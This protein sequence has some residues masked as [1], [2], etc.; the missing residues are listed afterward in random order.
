M[1]APQQLTLFD[2]HAGAELHEA[3][4]TRRLVQLGSRVIAFR[5]ARSRR[6]TIGI[7]VDAEG[8]S[9]AAPHYAPWV[10]IEKFLVE[11]TRWIL[12]KLDEWSKAGRPVRVNG[13]PGEEIPVRGRMLTLDLSQ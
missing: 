8:L 1:P 2:V 4:G 7:S 12:N 13:I 11:K 5:F 6:R 10:E 9:V 3:A